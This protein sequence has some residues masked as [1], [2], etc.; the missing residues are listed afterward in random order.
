MVRVHLPGTEAFFE[1]LILRIFSRKRI[2]GF[3]TIASRLGSEK[4]CTV[5]RGKFA[6][7]FQCLAPE[8]NLHIAGVLGNSFCFPDA[9]GKVL[10]E[11]SAIL[12]GQLAAICAICIWTFFERFYIVV[13][14]FVLYLWS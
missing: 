6:T 12:A 9:K 1:L 14:F 8:T 11:D 10:N 3:C 13:M 7:N 2:P 4:D 5:F